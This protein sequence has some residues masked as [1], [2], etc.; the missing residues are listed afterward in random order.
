MALEERSDARCEKGG[1]RRKGAEG[2][3]ESELA[4]APARRT[5]GTEE[6]G[7]LA[8]DGAARTW[9]ATDAAEAMAAIVTCVS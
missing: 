4:R 5:S 1:V 2:Q 8:R 9:G 3:I 6:G 7:T